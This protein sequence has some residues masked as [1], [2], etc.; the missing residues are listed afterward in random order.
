MTALKVIIAGGRNFR[1]YKLLKTECNMLI[2]PGVFAAF[3]ETV[4][5]V[6][7][8]CNMGVHTFTRD[9]GTKVFGADGLGE[10]YA[11]EYGFP[12]KLFPADWKRFNK[13]AGPVRNSQMVAYADAL[14]AFWDNISRGTGDVIKKAR[15]KK[16]FLKI[17]E[18]Y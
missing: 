4:E 10:R 16:I 6:S 11:K 14:I 18:P 9:D 1:D 12:V 13:S 15:D 2:A 7:G 5:I 8:C 3:G 17:V